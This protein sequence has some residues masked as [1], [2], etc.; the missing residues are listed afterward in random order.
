MQ[1]NERKML[2]YDLEKT[3]QDKHFY[4]IGSFIKMSD[5]TEVEEKKLICEEQTAHIIYTQTQP[6]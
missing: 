3:R 5:T 2:F 4:I 6:L 1:N